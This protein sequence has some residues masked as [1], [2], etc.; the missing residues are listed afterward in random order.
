M[1]CAF[2]CVNYNG[3]QVTSKFVSSVRSL[4]ERAGP[5]MVEAIIVDNA[6][7]SSDYESLKVLVREAWGDAKVIRSDVNLGYFGGL[8]LQSG[9]D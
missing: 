7:E 1:K 8:N 5:G 2:I 9:R 4:S 6:S 3:S